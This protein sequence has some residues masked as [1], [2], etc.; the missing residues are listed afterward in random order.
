MTATLAPS[1][2]MDA[3]ELAALIG[4]K[5]DSVRWYLS[6]RPE[7]LP[8]RVKWSRKPLWSRA[9]VTAWLAAR[10]GMAE[11]QAPRASPT[12]ERAPRA[13]PRGRPRNVRQ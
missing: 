13:S 4:L 12:V 8:P 1:D 9:V 3:A 2:M 10:D 7:R 6:Q 11:L 5:T